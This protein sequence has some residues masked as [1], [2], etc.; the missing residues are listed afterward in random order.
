MAA[1][2]A[3]RSARQEDHE[4][5]DGHRAGLAAGDRHRDRPPAVVGQRVEVEAL[6]LAV[7]DADAKALGEQRDEQRQDAIE[8][9]QAES[10]RCG[11]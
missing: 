1:V 10:A 4:R 7:G 2:V 9:V 8:V 5:R 6:E 3:A 11:R